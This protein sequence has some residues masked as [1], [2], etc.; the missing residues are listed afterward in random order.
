MFRE[1]DSHIQ[2]GMFDSVTALSTKKQKRLE[3]SK[4]YHFYNILFCN[5]DERL[6]SVLYSNKKSRPNIPINILVGALL[7]QTSKG[8]SIL[9]LLDHIDFDLLT[10]TA[11]GLNDFDETPFC[12]ASYYN[13][14]NKLLAYENETQENLL[15][16]LFNQLTKEQLKSLK[17]KAS[18]QRMDSFQACSNIRKYSRIELLIEVLL[19]LFKVL[20]KEDQL[21]YKERLSHYLKQSSTRYVYDISKDEFPKALGD[22]A[23]IYKNI[24]SDFAQKYSNV[25][26]FETFKRVYLEHFI[27]DEDKITAIKQEDLKGG[28]T[29]QSPDDLEATYRSKR[30]ESFKGQVIN[31][32]ETA[33]PE[34]V[35]NLITD[36]KVV[37]NIVDDSKIL[38]EQID[39]LKEK[40][41]DLKEL[42]TDGAYGSSA[43]DNKMEEHKV[44]HIP[45]AVRGR[46]ANVEIKID[47]TDNENEF[48]VSCPHQRVVS[49]P[50][51][52]RFKA[53]FNQDICENCPLKNECQLKETKHARVFYFTKEMVTTHQR[54]QNIFKIPKERRKIRPNVEATVKEFYKG[55][56]HKGKLKVRGLFKTSVFATIMSMAINFGRIYRLKVA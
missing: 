41:P 6:F 33:H 3:R 31:V 14:Q 46:K 22:L 24:N 45:T 12:E 36:V 17:I 38:N 5:I 43:N 35:I 21:K 53:N 11:L 47:E 40:T 16:T 39:Q 7:L 26:E 44:L 13:F 25:K 8:W 2:T 28:A 27:F 54:N 19:R 9:E 37:A 48:K 20:T 15:D 1:N 29:L 10:R 42:H 4:E 56:N 55:F 49:K 32:S 18:I 50:T 51:S 34:N 23:L 30:N 52:R